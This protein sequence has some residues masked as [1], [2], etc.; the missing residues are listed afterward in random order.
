MEKD[1]SPLRTISRNQ[2]NDLQKAL[3]AKGNS[4]VVNWAF[5]YG[6]PSIAD[7]IAELQKAGCI[8]SP[9][10]AAPSDGYPH[11]TRLLP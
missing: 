11:C 8:P 3:E 9:L 5:R 2:A 10:E 1:E 6:E 4:V 7:G